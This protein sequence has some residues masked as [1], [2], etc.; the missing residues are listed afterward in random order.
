MSCATSVVREAAQYRTQRFGKILRAIVIEGVTPRNH[1]GLDLELARQTICNL[2]INR[3]RIA[4]YHE[5]DG[6]PKG[7][8]ICARGPV[9]DAP[10]VSGGPAA[11]ASGLPR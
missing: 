6:N 10:R 9:S 1:D 8:E 3:Q 5:H 4:R 7:N 2:P 11:D